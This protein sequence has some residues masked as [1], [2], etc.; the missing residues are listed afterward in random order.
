MSKTFK[1]RKCRKCGTTKRYV[2][3]RVCVACDQKRLAKMTD[4]Q[5]SQREKSLQAMS[6]GP[7]ESLA[8]DRLAR[9][10]GWPK[11][12]TEAGDYIPADPIWLME[13]RR[14]P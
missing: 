3:T 2:E 10:K 13:Q 5:R 9:P 1:G 14:T 6:T 7:V 11:F 8:P 4:Y 12:L